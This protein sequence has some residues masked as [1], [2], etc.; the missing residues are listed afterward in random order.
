[1][2]RQKFNGCFVTIEFQNEKRRIKNAA[3]HENEQK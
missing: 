1:M 3:K 2:A